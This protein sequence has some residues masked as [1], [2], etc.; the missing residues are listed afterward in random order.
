[1]VPLNHLTILGLIFSPTNVGIK[2]S[3]AG[4]YPS[5]RKFLKYAKICSQY[6]LLTFLTAVINAV[7]LS[8]V[9][10]TERIS[11]AK[12]SSP[13]ALLQLWQPLTASHTLWNIQ[14]RH[15]WENVRMQSVETFVCLLLTIF[16]FLRKLLK[17]ARCPFFTEV[18]IFLFIFLRSSMKVF[19]TSRLVF[20][21]LHHVHCVLEKCQNLLSRNW[22]R[23]R[24]T[25][26]INI[27]LVKNKKHI[28]HLLYG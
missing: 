18:F 20:S 22:H 7:Q 3:T 24:F 6:L 25:N 8:K 12:Q 21:F 5:Q 16:P 4:S 10:K 14:A 23:G 1:M 17:H 19:P 27:S 2:H 15:W 11:L 26:R 9:V 28:K 13:Q